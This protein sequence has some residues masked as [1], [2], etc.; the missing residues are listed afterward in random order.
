MEFIIKYKQKDL[1]ENLKTSDTKL[2]KKMS[3]KKIETPI[4]YI[5]QVCQKQ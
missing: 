2:I 5:F 4:T 1:I 3:N